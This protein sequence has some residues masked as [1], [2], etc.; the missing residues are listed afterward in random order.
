MMRIPFPTNSK[1]SLFIA[2]VGMTIVTSICTIELYIHLRGE[3]QL[4]NNL[5][6]HVLNA[7]IL[8]IL[9][10]FI[11]Y[12]IL[13][14]SRLRHKDRKLTEIYN[15][16]TIIAHIDGLGMA[17]YNSSSRQLLGY[18]ERFE[19]NNNFVSWQ[20]FLGS[21]HPNDRKKLEN[22]EKDIHS[23]NKQSHIVEAR[24]KQY[25]TNEYKWY[26]INIVPVSNKDKDNAADYMFL[27]RNNEERHKA[28]ENLK[29]Y[30][31]QMSFISFINGIIFIEYNVALDTFFR[32]DD[33]ADTTQH[34]IP[35]DLWFSSFYADDFQ[36]SQELISFLR[37]H[38]EETF[39]TEY[40]YK[41]LNQDFYSWFTV[42]VSASGYDDENNITQYMCLVINND[43]WHNIID[44]ISRL[45][46][47]AELANRLKTSFLS[48]ISHE[49]RTP[50]NAVIGFSDI[51]CEEESAE[52]R[53]KYKHL[54]HE[55]NQ[56]LLQKIDDIIKLSML[57]SGTT[58]LN[59]LTFDVTDFFLDLTNVLT[60]TTK[61]EI[62]IICRQ[63][64]RFNVTVDPLWL[65]DV[66]SALLKNAIVA[67]RGSGTVALNYYPENNGLYV[68]VIDNGIGISEED[69][70]RIFDRFEKVNPFISGTGL[71]LSICKKIIEK[72]NGHI[73]VR[74]KLGEGSTFW[75]W[76]PCDINESH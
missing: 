45:R 55:N 59:R 49:I 43:K 16:L 54:I 11:I 15:N 13:S 44:E 46:D 71:G 62:K 51:I 39:H 1:V 24:Y 6:F 64:M 17:L 68:E 31:K 73:G 65:N 7:A 10:I 58:E 33:D 28:L 72:S 30:Q 37:A 69:Q 74:S 61:P 75:F 2:I 53:M 56:E 4:S 70:K 29:Y 5:L 35:L 60:K 20:D 52:E 22:L 14:N 48:N 41:L 47:K 18:N 63:N 26:E 66:V 36:K 21:I 12:F 27:F 67:L 3:I 8:S 19:P 9:I 42:H 23:Y 32:L 57:E 25:R 40:R 38:K 34:E 76:V 50:L